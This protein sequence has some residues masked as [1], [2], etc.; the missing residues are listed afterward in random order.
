[1]LVVDFAGVEFIG[2]FWQDSG[3]AEAKLLGWRFWEDW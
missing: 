2:G 3:S 1:V